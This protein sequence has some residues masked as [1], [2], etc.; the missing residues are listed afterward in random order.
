[1]LRRTL[2]KA[3]LLS[4]GVAAMPVR[5]LRAFSASTEVK[6]VLLVTKCHLD[7]GFSQTQTKILRQYF[8]VYYPEAMRTAAKLRAGGKDRYTW[9]TAAWLLYMY[10]EQAS[11]NQRELA[12]QAIEN[13]DLAWHAMP[14]NW[15]TEMLDRSMIDGCMAFSSTLDRRFNRKTIGGKMTDVPGHSRGIIAPLASAGVR[16][17]DIGV[18]AAS[19]PPEVPDI[20]LWRDPLGNSLAMM[21]HHHDYGGILL[22]PGTN[23]AVDIEVRNDNSG[24]HTIEEITAIYKKLRG[25]FPNAMVTASTMNE[26]AAAVD[27]IRDQLPIVTQEIGDTWIYGVGSDPNK[28][29]RYRELARLRRNWIAAGQ[30]ATGD[31]T[32]RRLLQSLALAA[33]HT[34]GTDTKSYLDNDHYRPDDLATVLQTTGYQVME[35][36]WQE[37]RENISAAVKS[38]PG[39]L[40][41]ETTDRLLKLRSQ[42]PSTEGLRPHQDAQ[43]FET[44]HYSLK[45]DRERGA[46]TRLISRKTGRE[47]ASPANPIALFTYQTLSAADYDNYL[48]RYVKSKEDWAPRDFGKPGIAK[49]NAASQEWH[50]KVDHLWV[51]N[52]ER[53]DHILLSMHIE[54]KT[55]ETSGNVAWPK[56]I[57]LDIQ[58]PKAEPRIDL[59]V[60]TMGKVQNRLPEAMWLTFAPMAQSH[61]GW[62]VEKVDQAVDVFDVVRGGGRT[63]HSITEKLRYQEG[64]H[65]FQVNTLD[66]P[67]VALGRRSPLN[68]SPEQPDL[69]QGVH[70]NLFNNAWGTN[71][72]QWAGGDWSYRFNLFA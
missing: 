69:S 22:I 16:L 17:L 49:F 52:D 45:I 56:G 2:L 8:D 34:W 59:R 38:L 63:M 51:S 9:T 10:L 24:P 29:A 19:T 23:V 25:T 60:T 37:K 5:G 3:G 62:T 41:D 53:A 32:D 68:F 55:A 35:V 47:W 70:F 42:A 18:N 4:A 13:N 31:P 44:A 67:L 54:D 40:I 15:Q 71:Y 7:V 64:P 6:R 61:G 48:S 72:V 46:I 66:A 20:F 11:S 36:S 14:F 57:Y 1:M 65:T 26:V 39:N 50:P 21:Y 28:V 43:T 33:E 58:L 30:F 27:G 12:E